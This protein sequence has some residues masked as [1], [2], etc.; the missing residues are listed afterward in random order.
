MYEYL[1][2]TEIKFILK[3][4]LTPLHLFV[5]YG[6]N[7]VHIN[8]MVEKNGVRSRSIGVEFWFCL[9]GLNGSS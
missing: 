6:N 1:K 5:S 2:S 7:N 3:I 9:G 8:G 4:R